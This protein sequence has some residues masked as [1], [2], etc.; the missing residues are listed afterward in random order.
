MA[1][2]NV[3]DYYEEGKKEPYTLSLY[4]V[5]KTINDQWQK[6]LGDEISGGLPMLP[7]KRRLDAVRLIPGK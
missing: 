5:H 7:E 1:D 4:V 3:L 6:W 2:V